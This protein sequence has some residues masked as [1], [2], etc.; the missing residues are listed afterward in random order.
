LIDLAQWIWDEFGLSITK[1]TLSCEMRALGFRKLSARPRHHGQKEDALADFKK[2]RRPTGSDNGQAAAQQADRAVVAGKARVDQ[3][4]GI[5]RR[6]ARRGTRPLSP[7]DQCMASAY[8]FGATRPAQGTGAAIVMPR[9]NSE[10]MGMHL[11]TPYMPQLRL[12]RHFD[13]ELQWKS[14]LHVATPTDPILAYQR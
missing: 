5:T 7:K 3:K 9:C 6:W 1:R 14:P 2:L 11:A 4:T 12:Q 8:I 13:T 10:A